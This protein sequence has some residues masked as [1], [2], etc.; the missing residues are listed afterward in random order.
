MTCSI[1]A[2][3]QLQRFTVNILSIMLL[4]LLCVSA[5][6]VIVREDDDDSDDENSTQI[7]FKAHSEQ[8]LAVLQAVVLSYGTHAAT[9]RRDQT[10]LWIPAVIRRWTAFAWPTSG[11]YEACSAIHRLLDRD[12]II[13]M[14]SYTGKRLTTVPPTHMKRIQNCILNNNVFLG[15]DVPLETRYGVVPTLNIK[16]EDMMLCGP[17]ANHTYQLLLRPSILP[18][19][20]E[21]VLDELFDYDAVWIQSQPDYTKTITTVIQ[22]GYSA[23]QIISGNGDSWAKLMIGVYLIMSLLQITSQFILPLQQVAYSIRCTTDKFE[24]DEI[25][26]K[27]NPLPHP[28]VDGMTCQD[29]R[30]WLVTHHLQYLALRKCGMKKE[31]AFNLIHEMSPSD[32][33]SQPSKQWRI[34]FTLVAPMLP[35]LLAIGAGYWRNSPVEAIVLTWIVLGIPASSLLV[36]YDPVFVNSWITASTIAGVILIPGTILV[37]A[38]TILGFSKILH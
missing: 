23:Y 6:P 36:V 11:V 4:S 1:Y 34:F 33:F 12:R 28:V 7:S 16:T 38:A 29:H 37:L 35:L 21:S 27:C 20:P 10:S 22:I 31:E 17:G 32:L 25:C 13:G 18:F 26:N 2:S 14:Q 3:N 5:A 30:K 19:L 8:A 9:V 24:E 15:Y